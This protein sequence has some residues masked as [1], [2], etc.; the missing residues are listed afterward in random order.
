MAE[1]RVHDRPG[2]LITLERGHGAE[3][4]TAFRARFGLGLP[5]MGAFTT[6]G[7]WLLA[8][9]APDR[10]FLFGPEAPFAAAEAALQGVAGVIDWSDARTGALVTGPDAR[11]LMRALLPIDLRPPAM[12]PGKC[13]QTVMTY[14]SV[15]VL[16]LDDAPTYELHCASSYR[17]SFWRAL[18]I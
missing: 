17:E 7:E 5:E 8:R 15:L 13:A 14:M 1:V 3:T 9:G 12:A 16:Q 4:D 6:A 10:A 2:A 11:R 18:G